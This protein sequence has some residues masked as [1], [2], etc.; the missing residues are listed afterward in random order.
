MSNLDK[1]Q[2]FLTKK[3]YPI[4]VTV[5]SYIIPQ[6]T[7]YCKKD[8]I[9]NGLIKIDEIEYIQIKSGDKLYKKDIAKYDSLQLAFKPE[10]L[11][12]LY[13]AKDGNDNPMSPDIPRVFEVKIR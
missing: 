12:I 13:P 3:I 6:G 2:A 7:A 11:A 5:S 4:G 1:R 8:S 9:L 10:E